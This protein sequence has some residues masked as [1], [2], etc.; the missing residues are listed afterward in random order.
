M[1]V[2]YKIQNEVLLYTGHVQVALETVPTIIGPKE[3]WGPWMWDHLTSEQV[4]ADNPAIMGSEYIEVPSKDYKHIFASGLEVSQLPSAAGET[5]GSKEEDGENIRDL[6]FSNGHHLP[7]PMADSNMSDA[8]NAGD[9]GTRVDRKGKKCAQID[10]I[11]NISSPVT[12][13]PK[14]SINMDEGNDSQA[15]PSQTPKAMKA[16]E[17]PYVMHA[18]PMGRS[19]YGE[20]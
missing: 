7:V 17:Q 5:A 3:E 4:H 16:E 19:A 1:N 6:M 8:R 15:G 10:D 9:T 14:N 18:R 12:K 2:S 20:W 11:I 13:W